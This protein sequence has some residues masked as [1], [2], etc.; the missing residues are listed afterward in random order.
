MTTE[1]R[2]R[3]IAVA[4]RSALYLALVLTLV[5]LALDRSAA[6]LHR[7]SGDSTAIVIYTT[8]WCAYC[9]ALRAHLDARDIPYADHD[10]ET[11]LQGGM[12]WWA[13]RGRGVPVS[14]IGPEIV[15]GFNLPAIDRALAALGYPPAGDPAE[16][17][18]TAPGSPL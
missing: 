11:T 17:P 18:S 3:R 2:A 7:P 16:L 15:H 5:L 4:R 1:G 9:A 10:V 13:L 8:A 12:G 14:V 6:W